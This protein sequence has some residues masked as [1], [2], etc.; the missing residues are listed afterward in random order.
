M[1]SIIVA[2]IIIVIIG[3]ISVRFISTVSS[4]MVTLI[5]SQPYSSN[6][7]LGYLENK[8]HQKFI[9]KEKLKEKL[10]SFSYIVYPANN[11]SLTFYVFDEYKPPSIIFLSYSPSTRELS[12]TYIAT[13]ITNDLPNI[14]QKVYKSIYI[15]EKD[16]ICS[17]KQVLTIPL[18][19]YEDIDNV[20]NVI[21]DLIK[22]FRTNNRYSKD[23]IEIAVN[24]N[25]RHIEFNNNNMLA[26]GFNISEDSNLKVEEIKNILTKA[27][28]N[29][30]R[31]FR[32]DELFKIPVNIKQKYPVA[33]FIENPYIY[34]NSKK[35]IGE[36]RFGYIN[37]FELIYGIE[38]IIPLI[39]EKLILLDQNNY[40][41]INSEKKVQYAFKKDNNVYLLAEG[42]RGGLN[43]YSYNNGQITLCKDGYDS[44]TVDEIDKFF[45]LKVVYDYDKEILNIY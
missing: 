27:F 20:T 35:P 26:S 42:D 19:N 16:K 6:K 43:I 39:K 38:N 41:I 21:S 18:I 8:Y 3:F 33:E 44:L 10:K 45:G 25:N 30:C 29:Q 17:Y 5:P 12:D 2:L 24:Y 1:N 36:V 11:K 9:I 37:G 32:D 14:Q 22:Y 28:I 13:L 40:K 15:A 23:N 31:E 4:T 7:I 34:V